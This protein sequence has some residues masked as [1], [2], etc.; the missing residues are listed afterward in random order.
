MIRCLLLVLLLAACQRDEGKKDIWIYTSLYKDTIADMTPKLE[1]AFPHLKINWYQAGSEEIA[2]KVN[3]ELIAGAP[4]ADIL[5]SSE[6]F[7]YQELSDSGKLVSWKP[8]Q[9]PKFRPEYQNDLGT[10]HIVSVPIMV[11]VYNSDAIKAEDA[12]KSFKDLTLPRYKGIATGGSPLASGTA[13]TTVLAMHHMY[14]WDYFHE[15]KA[16]GF[17][18]DGG[19]S[20]VMK[21]IQTKER[22]IGFVLLENVLRFQQEDK[23]LKTIYPE[24]GVVTQ[25][26]T[27][28]IPKRDRPMNE[29]LALADWFFTQEGQETM[30]KSYMHSP[31]KGFPP[32]VGAPDLGVLNQSAF[33]WTGDLIRTLTDK[34]FEIKET[35][36]EIM[37]K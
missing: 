30:T 36:V 8:T 7:W 14:G 2:A 24:D 25:F 6:R 13:F 37:F 17:L 16:N 34:R 12:P 27:M 33:P 32:P 23:R 9:F 29:T 10:F 20:A 19:N 15:L 35:Y 21:R 11:L 1:K 28:G 5:I 26:N 22:P 3:T 4:K 31:L 18:F